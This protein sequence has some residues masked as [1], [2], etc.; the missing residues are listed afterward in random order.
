MGVVEA[1]ISLLILFLLRGIIPY[2]QKWENSESERY[3]MKTKEE[4]GY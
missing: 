1:L 4:G 2:V 3:M